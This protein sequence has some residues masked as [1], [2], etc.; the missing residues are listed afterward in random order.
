MKYCPKCDTS[1]NELE[2][3][4]NKAR[5]DKL[6]SY[7]KPCKIQVTSAYQ[8]TS[9]G[10]AVE[11]KCRKTKRGRAVSNKA[12][13]K[14]QQTDRGKEV[15][16]KYRMSKEGKASVNAASKKYKQTERGR[17]KKQ[18]YE[19]KRYQENIEYY[20]LKNRSRKSNGASIETL[21]QVL[22]R[23]KVCQLCHTDKDLQFDHIFPVSQGGKG[24][25]ENLQL[26]CGTC[27]NF[28][29][30]NL[31]LPDGGMLI[32]GKQQTIR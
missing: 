1:K 7:C 10:K 27:N 8:K 5:H 28:K 3:H 12:S 9:K 22:K 13:K 31:F 26:L 30:N 17:E 23:D 18:A 24:S 14:Y 20:R 16:E 25:L 2:F 21:K 29:S 32:I 11:S 4:K 15:L 6:E 19:R